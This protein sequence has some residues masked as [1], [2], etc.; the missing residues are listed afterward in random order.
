MS[1]TASPWL[2]AQGLAASRGGTP[3]FR[4]LDFELVPGLS[5]VLGG[6]GR[7]KTTL[8]SVLAGEQPPDA[9]VLRRHVPLQ[10]LYV[11][12]ESPQHDAQRARDWL[13]Q[14][15]ER[16]PRWSTPSADA[17]VQAFALQEHLDKQMHML[18]AGSRRKLGLLAAAASG[19][20]LVLL[21]TP[22]AALDGRSRAVLVELL[23]EAC[24]SRDQVWVLAD[25][26]RPAGLDPRDFALHLDLG[27]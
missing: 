21:D 14:C 26:V 9:G 4:D 22:F 8:L 11:Q 24:A 10:P 2:S 19:A 12:P 1:A 20:G 23:R 7:G 17:L 27:D 16:Q 6:E 25:Y 5:L 13:A 3:L 18:S 15:R